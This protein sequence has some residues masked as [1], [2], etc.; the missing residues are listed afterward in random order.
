MLVLAALPRLAS[1]SVECEPPGP[2]RSVSIRHV[3][4]G[5]TVI[6]SDGDHARL[7]GI[8]TPEIDHEGPDDEPLAAE[9]RDAL[10]DL[11]AS[12][13]GRLA[14]HAPGKRRD[15]HGR[16]LIHL[17]DP[18][19]RNLQAALLER[20]LAVATFVAPNLE[21]AE[22][23]RRAERTARVNRRGLWKQRDTVTPATDIGGG[24][25]GFRTVAGRLRSSRRFD[26]GLRLRFHDDF[27][28][29]L[30]AEAL[31][32]FDTE[33]AELVNRRVLVRGWLY[34]FRGDAA[35][36]VEHPFALID[37]DRP[38]ARCPTSRDTG[39]DR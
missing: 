34:G 14:A 37:C 24:T 18:G 12:A 11:V 13:S 1:T 22:C 19:H 5:D 15:R 9:A 39:A 7:I 36:R 8:N 17:V 3:I 2:G 28:L 26:S 29:W 35:L 21:L 27:H 25:R 23:Y 31:V 16:R 20:G 10:A 4:D 33:P 6:L 30:P 38:S 32:R